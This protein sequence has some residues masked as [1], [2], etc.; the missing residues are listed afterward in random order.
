[1][2]AMMWCRP[3]LLVVGIFVTCTS[4]ATLTDPLLQDRANGSVT[5]LRAI[6]IIQQSGIFDISASD[7]LRLIAFVETRDG[8][9]HDTFRKGYDGGIWAVDRDDF[10]STKSTQLYHGLSEKLE[11]IAQKFNIH[12]LYVE[13]ADLRK[14]LF[15]ALAARLVI[16]NNSSLLLPSNVQFQMEQN[17]RKVKNLPTTGRGGALHMLVS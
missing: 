10:M 11:L 12:W 5:V 6:S 9:N 2:A 8:T 17:E 1:M 14:P 3:F 15:S 7:T 16:F 13:W 4:S